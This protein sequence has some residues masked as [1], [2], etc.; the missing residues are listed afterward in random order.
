MR[1]P[2]V[3]GGSGWSTYELA[4]TLR[5]N[6]H[7]VVVSRPVFG[8]AAAGVSA[9]YDAFQVRE[10]RGWAPP[11]P[12]VRNYVK[13]ERLYGHYARALAEIVRDEQI[14]LVHGQHLLSIPAAVRAARAERRPVVRGGPHPSDR[15]SSQP[16]WNPGS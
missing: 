13:N 11:V 1:F 12:F 10:Y 3:C 16:R 15:C 9:V 2:P 8:P 4:K 14:D 6:D 7:H 5:A